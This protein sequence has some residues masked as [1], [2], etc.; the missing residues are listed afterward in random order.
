MANDVTA[1]LNRT[2][3]FKLRKKKGILQR[4]TNL[5]VQN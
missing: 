1:S 2:S 5:P 3:L 4:Q